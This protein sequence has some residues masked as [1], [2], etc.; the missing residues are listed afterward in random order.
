M[1]LQ[2]IIALPIAPHVVL[3]PSILIARLQLDDAAMGSQQSTP[4]ALGEMI[5]GYPVSDIRKIRNVH[6]V[7]GQRNVWHKGFDIATPTGTPVYAPFVGTVSECVEDGRWKTYGI[8]QSPLFPNRY[9]LLHHLSWCQTGEYKKGDVWA[10]TGNAGTGPH[11]HVEGWVRREGLWDH[12]NLAK[13]WI[14][15]F[16]DASINCLG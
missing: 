3:S 2:S 4:P 14:R 5:A 15:G 11:L 9:W 10:K 16:I 7:S 1:V 8:F 13:G 12:Y 6:P